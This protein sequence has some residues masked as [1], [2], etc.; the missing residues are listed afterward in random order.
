VLKA[1]LRE[2]LR[3]RNGE[4]SIVV[5]GDRNSREQ[6]ENNG[7]KERKVIGKK[8]GN[9]G[10]TK[11]ADEH[12]VLGK[13]RV[14]ALQASS[15]DEDGLHR[16]KAVVVVGLLRKLFGTQ[17]VKLAHL[18]RER[19]GVAE[20]FG[21]KHDLGNQG[22][23]RDHHRYRAEADLQIVGELRAAGVTRVHG[24][25]N[26]VVLEGNLDSHEIDT[27]LLGDAAL[28]EHNH[29]LSNDGQHLNVD[30]TTSEAS[31]TS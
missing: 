4:F 2:L 24:D 23:I 9:I 29:L 20:T 18:P 1:G 27:A 21:E 17:N 28:T 30:S 10:I 5:V 13:I 16:A 25:N 14:T 7:T 15:H 22:V 26:V 6:I 31:D 8:L 19:L 11:S 3:H 12:E